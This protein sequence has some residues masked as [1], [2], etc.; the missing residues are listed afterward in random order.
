MRTGTITTLAAAVVTVMF[1]IVL[2]HQNITTTMLSDRMGDMQDH[3]SD[4]MTSLEN[5]FGRVE[6][7][8]DNRL[9]RIDTRLTERQKE[10]EAILG[11]VS[12]AVAK[13]V[14]QN[15]SHQE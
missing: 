2:W 7:S 15:A 10:N 13:H 6:T 4:R 5:Q 1:G 8:L 9:T 12:T 11:R 14:K 3:L